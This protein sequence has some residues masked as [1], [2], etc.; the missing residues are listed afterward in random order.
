MH[1]KI[2]GNLVSVADKNNCILGLRGHNQMEKTL[3][4]ISSLYH[5]Q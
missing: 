5:P 1:I 2:K 3:G 4:L